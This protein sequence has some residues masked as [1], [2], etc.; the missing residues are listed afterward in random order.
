MASDNTN[1]LV[2]TKTGQTF[3][4]EEVLYPGGSSQVL[5]VT[6]SKPSWAKRLLGEKPRIDVHTIHQDSIALFSEVNASYDTLEYIS[7]LLSEAEAELEDAPAT[8][9]MDSIED[10]ENALMSAEEPEGFTSGVLMADERY[11]IY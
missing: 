8:F 2:T 7:E 3:S 10:L 4:A 6:R 1:I 11:Y 9:D 5:I